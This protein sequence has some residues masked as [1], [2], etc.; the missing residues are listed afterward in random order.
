MSPR[1]QIQKVTRE[2]LEGKRLLEDCHVPGIKWS[3]LRRVLIATKC[4]LE[5][6]EDI[7][8]LRLIENHLTVKM[9]RVES[10][11]IAVDT[12]DDLQRVISFLNQD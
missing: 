3:A 9:I 10:K 1:D 5:S 12:P 11:S 4:H 7:E 8:I 2:Y 6:I